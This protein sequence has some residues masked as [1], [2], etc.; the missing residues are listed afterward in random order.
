MSLSTN[1]FRWVIPTEKTHLWALYLVVELF[2]IYVPPWNTDTHTVGTNLLNASIAGKGD[3]LCIHSHINPRWVFRFFN[4]GVMSRREILVLK[5]SQWTQSF[6]KT[7]HR[8]IY[9]EILEN[10]G[11][12]THSTLWQARA[13]V[14]NSDMMYPTNLSQIQK[15]VIYQLNNHTKTT[16]VFRDLLQQ[17][18]RRPQGGK[19]IILTNYLEISQDFLLDSGF[20]KSLPCTPVL[21]STIIR[22][23][24]LKAER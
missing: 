9:S 22:A 3:W 6:W 21:T 7:Q 24:F 4:L 15:A 2:C 10:E 14:R 13:N 18:N 8:W 17:T 16:P 12:R 11:I 5:N 20:T 23:L 1:T 19:S